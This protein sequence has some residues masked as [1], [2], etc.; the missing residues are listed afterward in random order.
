MHSFEVHSNESVCRKVDVLGCNKSIVHRINKIVVDVDALNWCFGYIINY[1]IDIAVLLRSCD[2]AKRP[3]AY[4]ITKF[5]DLVN[6]KITETDN[7]SSDPPPFL[8][9]DILHQFSQDNTTH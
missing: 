6:I 8:T 1:N 3:C 5:R 4:A 2:L 9:S 7:P